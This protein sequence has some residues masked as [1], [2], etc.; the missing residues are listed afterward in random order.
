[1]DQPKVSRHLAM[2]RETGLVLDERRG[3][4][5]HYRL[6]P[7]LPAW[8]EAILDAAVDGSAARAES[9]SDPNPYAPAPETS[10]GSRT[11]HE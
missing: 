5:V 9:V 8:V 7:E 3:Q 1:M 4:W 10:L 11:R 6:A 2:L